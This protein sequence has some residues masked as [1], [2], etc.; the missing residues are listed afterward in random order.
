MSSGNDDELVRVLEEDGEL[1]NALER[2]ETAAAAE[3][4][5]ARVLRVEAGP[6]E[7]PRPSVDVRAGFG[8]LV[9][10]GLLTREVVLAGLGCTELLGKGDVLRPWG[11]EEGEPSLPLTVSWSALEPARIALLDRAFL[12]AVA[13]WPTVAATLVA[14]LV[15]RSHSLAMHLAISRLVGIDLRL[16]AL[17]WHLADRFGHAGPQGVVVPLRLTHETLAKIVS[18]RRPSVTSALGQLRERRLLEARDDETWILRGNPRR[19][20]ESMLK[21]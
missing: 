13:P 6:W 10:D 20:I 3:R 15:R 18:A 14:R 4:A 5:L 12:N 21:R 7:P 1:A 16:Y 19:E 2:A 9:L 17:F 11:D 8:L